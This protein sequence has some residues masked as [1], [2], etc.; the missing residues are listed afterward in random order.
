MICDASEAHVLTLTARHTCLPTLED[1][2]AARAVYRA[3]PPVNV[4]VADDSSA[5]RNTSAMSVV[6]PSRAA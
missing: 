2:R 4:L 6:R 1:A 5:D 3:R